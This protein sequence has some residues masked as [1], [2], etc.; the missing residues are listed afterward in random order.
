MWALFST[1]ATSLFTFPPAL[2]NPYN[3]NGEIY[4]PVY[5]LEF[6]SPWSQ[7]AH[8]LWKG[9]K[10]FLLFILSAARDVHIIL[11]AIILQ[12]WTTKSILM[13]GLL[14]LLFKHSIDCLKCV[15][16]DYQYSKYWKNER[17]DISLLY[18][19]STKIAYI[20]WNQWKN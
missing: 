5:P 12:E 16:R 18:V 4:G 20:H 2:T 15:V 10:H 9:F 14:L 11:V 6:E 7:V 13:K 1:F 3:E 19:C 17:A 8:S